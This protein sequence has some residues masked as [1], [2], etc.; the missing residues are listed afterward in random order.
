MI[1]PDNCFQM[2]RADGSPLVGGV[3]PIKPQPIRLAHNV[4]ISDTPPTYDI[5]RISHDWVKVLRSHKRTDRA[6]RR[7]GRARHEV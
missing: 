4:G 3:Y 2:M 1:L 6:A 7:A 5:P